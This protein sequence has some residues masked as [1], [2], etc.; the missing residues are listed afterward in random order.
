MDIQ[1]L[2][3][4]GELDGAKL[5]FEIKRENRILTINNFAKVYC[6][7]IDRACDLYYLNESENYYVQ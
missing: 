5:G 6:L 3:A 2:G 1:D 7:L 4:I